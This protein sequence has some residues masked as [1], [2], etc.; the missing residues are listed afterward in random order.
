MKK[1][2]LFL[3]AA[4]S[5]NGVFSQ[6][7]FIQETG[8]TQPMNVIK[9]TSVNTGY[10][11][12]PSGRI[13]R[14][15]NAGLVWNE[16]VTNFGGNIF[17]MSFPNALIGYAGGVSGKLIKTTN[18]GLNW[19]EINTNHP[20]IYSVHFTDAS[21]GFLL[22]QSVQNPAHS[23]ILKSTNG[24]L[25][26]QSQFVAGVRL[27]NI[28]NTEG[29]FN[30]LF[31][32]GSNGLILKTTDYGDTWQGILPIYG[33]IFYAIH[34]FSGTFALAAG[35]NSIYRS[36]NSGA[37]WSWLP[38]S[39][40]TTFH[41]VQMVN[42]ATGYTA[43]SSGHIF[44]TYNGGINW[45]QL[46]YEADSVVFSSIFF[47]S[48]NT[49]YFARNDGR[50]TKTTNGGGAPIGINQTGSESPAQFSLLQNFPNPF[51]PETNIKFQIPVEAIVKL[52][53]FDA[54]GRDVTTLVNRQL[55]PGSYEAKWY[56]SAYP[57][58][59]YFYTLA[60]GSFKETKKMVLIK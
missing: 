31:A 33:G 7:W 21:T 29:S 34:P 37:N 15:T 49:G 18:S 52:T 38:L 47:T 56:A 13:F 6:S 25:N 5:F 4:F 55:K 58:G 30:V 17:D 32:C 35:V 10:C 44:K 41:D 59:I 1:I 8:S 48:E 45:Y 20:Q 14:T 11:A 24:G 26:W 2:L 39:P 27:Y 40:P 57:S 36:S 60:S 53:I 19:F 50:I 54:L 9:F 3:T 46:D 42:Q 23:A 28:L 16:I 51:N 12:G 43:G 22:V